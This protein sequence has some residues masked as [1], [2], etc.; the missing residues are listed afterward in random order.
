MTHRRAHNVETAGPPRSGG[1]SERPPQCGGWGFVR[2]R[3]RSPG[4]PLRP[5]LD[6][7]PEEQEGQ[8]LLPRPDGTPAPKGLPKT[9]AICN[10]Y[11][12]CS[13]HFAFPQGH[14]RIWLT[15]S[16]TNSVDGALPVGP[17]GG[18]QLTLEHL[19]GTRQRQGL[20]AELDGLWHLVCGD[21]LA[22]W[23]VSSSSMTTSP[24]CSCG[25]PMTATC[26]TAGWLAKAFSTSVEY[27]FSPHDH[28]LH[29]VHQEEIAVRVRHPPSGTSRRAAR[30]LSPP[31][32][33]STQP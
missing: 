2:V 18:T 28:V 30:P 24:H 19:H 21:P 8:V 16:P 12:L 32:D 5:P 20:G 9:A 29:P 7:G 15:A 33:A 10:R 31:A 4:H 11:F 6:W 14:A 17:A 3:H 25:M 23:A 13:L 27:T 22:P 26:W 1:T